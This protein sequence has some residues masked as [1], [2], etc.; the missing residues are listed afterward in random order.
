MFRET[1]GSATK[2]EPAGHPNLLNLANFETQRLFKEPK[3][4]QKIEL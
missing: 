4:N 1:S 3:L 2:S